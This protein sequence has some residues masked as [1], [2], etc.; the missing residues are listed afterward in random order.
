MDKKRP[1]ADVLNAASIEFVL[2]DLDIAMTLMDVASTTTVDET[3][4]RNHQNA[5]TAYDS[6]LRLL[7]HIK[8]NA[9]QHYA[10][11]EKLAI[12]KARLESV[13]QQF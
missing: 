3:A 2:T 12:L 4:Q 13:G 6:M 9:S 5:R 1:L 11:D 10:L 8:L 7:P